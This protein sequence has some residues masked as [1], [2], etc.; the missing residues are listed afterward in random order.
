M[1]VLK[2]NTLQACQQGHVLN[3]VIPATQGIENFLA[4]ASCFTHQKENGCWT[5]KELYNGFA[6]TASKKH[7]P[8]ALCN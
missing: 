3:V 1:H 8:L 2:S 6:A 5:T 7:S 4:V